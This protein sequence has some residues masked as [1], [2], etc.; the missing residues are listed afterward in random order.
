MVSLPE[1]SDDPLLD[2]G[3]GTCET[4][5]ARADEAPAGGLLAGF[6]GRR[7]RID[8]VRAGRPAAHER[9]DVALVV[10]EV[11]ELRGDDRCRE[12]S[13]EHLCVFTAQAEAHHRRA[14]AEDGR[15]ARWRAGRA[16]ASR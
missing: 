4:L 6:R 8:Q 1:E 12:L 13:S 15:Q 5:E 9:A 7:K 16:S 14:V 11:L 2:G 10:G 3:A